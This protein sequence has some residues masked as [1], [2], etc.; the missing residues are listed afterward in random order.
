MRFC[1]FHYIQKNLKYCNLLECNIFFGISVDKTERDDSETNKNYL[2]NSQ[3]FPCYCFQKF[4]KIR[5]PNDIS[6]L[7]CFSRLSLFVG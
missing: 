6:G 3:D 7:H 5:L 1:A 2:K 4:N